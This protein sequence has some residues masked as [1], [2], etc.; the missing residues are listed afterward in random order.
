MAF[1]M[2]VEAGVQKPQAGFI[3]LSTCGKCEGGLCSRYI[4][5]VATEYHSPMQCPSDP[6]GFNWVLVEE[7]P[8]P[9][10]PDV[11]AYLTP[12]L[13]RY[14]EQAANALQRQDW[15]ASGAMSRKVVDVSTQQRLGTDAKKFGTIKQRIDELA[16]RGALTVDLKEW[17]HVIRLEGNDASH[18]E[19]PYSE[20]EAKEL[21]SFAELYLTYVH[22]LPGRLQAKRTTPAPAAAPT[23]P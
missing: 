12:Q 23:T 10:S 2:R 13:R 4:R 21:L 7:Y 11:P 1:N 17:A 6:I 5:A 9:K 22:T 14:F 15:D 16:R 8:A 20:K 18:D 3:V 19:D